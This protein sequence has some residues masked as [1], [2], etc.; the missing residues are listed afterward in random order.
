[1]EMSNAQRLILSNQYNLMSQLDPSNA[2][3]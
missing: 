2:A 3:K 1:M